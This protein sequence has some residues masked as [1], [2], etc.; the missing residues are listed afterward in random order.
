MLIF[1]PASGQEWEKTYGSSSLSQFHDLEVLHDSSVIATGFDKGQL[2]IIRIDKHGKPL[3]EQHKKFSAITSNPSNER[4]INLTRLSNGELILIGNYAK[5]L[6]G[7]KDQY[8]YHFNA[9]GDSIRLRIWEDTLDNQSSTIVQLISTTDGGFAFLKNA[10]QRYINGKTLRST[11]TLTKFNQHQKYSWIETYDLNTTNSNSIVWNEY[12]TDLTEQN[13]T[14]YISGFLEKD[15]IVNLTPYTIERRSF[16]LKTDANGQLD[17]MQNKKSGPFI[18]S[19]TVAQNNMLIGIDNDSIF[20]IE[21]NS[22]AVISTYNYASY[23]NSCIGTNIIEL[24]DHTAAIIGSLTSAG[25]KQAVLVKTNIHYQTIWY[26]EFGGAQDEQLFAIANYFNHGFYLGGSTSSFGNNAYLLKTNAFGKSLSRY[27]GGTAFDDQ[28]NNCKSDKFETYLQNILYRTVINSDTLYSVSSI[29][30]NYSFLLDTAS[31]G[32]LNVRPFLGPY[33]E[34]NCSNSFDTIVQSGLD[35]IIFD[36]PLS[37]KVNCPYLTVDISTARLRR[38]FDNNYVVQ[39]CNNGTQTAINAYVT[40][41]LDTLLTY[42]S[43][44]LPFSNQKGNAFK[45]P[46]GNVLAGQCGNFII[47]TTVSCDA[48]LGRSHKVIASIF[49]DT[50]CMGPNTLWDSSHLVITG[51]CVNNDSVEFE[52][53][54]SGPGD[55]GGPR[56][57]IVIEDIIMI[58]NTPIQLASGQKHIIKFPANGSTYTAIIDQSI[59]HPY[60]TFASDFVEGCG[61]NNQGTFSMG[62]ANMHPQPDEAPFISID[63]QENIGSWDPNDKS[64]SPKGVG[65]SFIT[66]KNTDLEYH[67]RFQ[68]TGTDTA[69]T[70]KIIDTIS[71]NLD[72]STLQLGTSS[73][74]FRLQIHG[75]RILQFTFYNINLPDS[76]TNEPASHGFVKFKIAQKP[77]LTDGTLIE[78]TAAIYFDFNK[79]IITNTVR[80]R[81]GEIS[82]FVEEIKRD[83]IKI[84]AYPNPLTIYT[85]I[86]VESVKEFKELELLVFD[87]EG[88]VIKRL[89]GYNTDQFELSA[90]DIPAGIYLFKLKVKGDEIGGGKIIVQ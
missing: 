24:P 8:I 76:N 71:R 81:I 17:W 11:I 7:Y 54:N 88:K 58:V 20:Q 51:S 14:F 39:Y 89:K 31:F 70:V 18:N 28:N 62:F 29:K 42:N 66:E 87:L 65:P 23:C 68:N 46:V 74:A 19:L 60:A 9:A 67:I 33:W 38:C 85:V 83:E 45:F 40:V 56:Q 4:L 32:N 22:G 57:L 64:V 82:V 21:T 26:K 25:N 53:R 86:K 12:A 80:N 47:N 6:N 44:S 16:V 43:S 69:F 90:Q 52:I 79:P 27:I 35:S 61:L 78:N 10:P 41:S 48:E 77:G 72:I 1:L 3:W 36:F 37:A 50:I 75:N 15:S 59:G 84:K 5:N 49:P 63:V 34:Y 73:H 2:W 13:N 55:M 30:G